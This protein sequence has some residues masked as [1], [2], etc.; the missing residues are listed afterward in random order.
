MSEPWIDFKEVKS[1]VSM[2]DLL[3]KY[4]IDLRKINQVQIRGKC[5]LPQHRSEDVT[6]FSVNVEKNIW[7]CQSSSCAEARKG[8]KGGN[9]LDFV[10]WMEQCNVREAAVRMSEWFGLSSSAP[11]KKAV[12]PVADSRQ[13]N[14]P[15]AFTLK[16]IDHRHPYLVARGFEEE[17]CEFL[18]VGFFP[19]NGSMKGRV[20]FPLRN[21]HG[22]V[23]GYSGRLVDDS[24]ISDENPRWRYPPAFVKGTFLYNLHNVEGEEVIVCEGEWGVLACVRAGVMNAVGLCGSVASDEQVKLLKGLPRVVICLDGDEA[25]REGTAKLASQLPQARVVRLKMGEQ[26]DHFDVD[27]LR[28]RL[29]RGEEEW[30]YTAVGQ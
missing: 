21:F 7:A 12:G 22:E 29:G 30:L 23:V 26:L 20:V 15:L 27:S 4:G 16:D 2:S 6:S 14:I 10:A 11:A 1:R 24:L 19:G 8:K 17:E 13:V 5:P 28:V 3:R 9:V 18:G 25:G